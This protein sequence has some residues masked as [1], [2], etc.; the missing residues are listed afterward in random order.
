MQKKWNKGKLEINFLNSSKKF[1]KPEKVLF[2]ID[3]KIVT[4]FKFKWNP[5]IL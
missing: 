4:I 5:P 3:N 2:V 1:N